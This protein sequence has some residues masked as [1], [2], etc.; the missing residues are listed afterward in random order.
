MSDDPETARQIAALA[1]DERPLLVLDVDEVV[2]EFIRPFTG[3]LNAQDLHL[4][5]DSF[6]LHGNVVHRETG[7]AVEDDRV[8]LLME[9]FFLVQGDWQVCAGGAPEVLQNLSRGAEIVMLTAMPHRHR[10]R[11]RALLDRLGLP[12]P[13]LT[14][15]L[16]KG[17]AVKMLRGDKHRPV[18]FIDDIPHNLVSVRKSV[19]DAALFH[20]MAHGEFRAL[21]PPLEAWVTPVE[22]WRDAEPKIAAALGI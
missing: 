14:T 3:F 10:D 2:L 12:Y 7:L 18:A 19:P 13:L 11:R 6:R 20:I 1:K 21:L 9:E 5:T 17:P 22:N 4:R 16:P 8:S 15:E